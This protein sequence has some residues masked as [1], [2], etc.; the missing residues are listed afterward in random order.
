MHPVISEEMWCFHCEHYWT[1]DDYFNCHSCPNCNIVPIMVFRTSSFTYMYA[2][3]AKHPEEEERM[4]V[5]L[6][7]MS[8]RLNYNSDQ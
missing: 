5:K 4:K 3:I 8:G 6:N 7:T 2:Y 1:T